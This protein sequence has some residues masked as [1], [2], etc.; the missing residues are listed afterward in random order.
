MIKEDSYFIIEWFYQMDLST[1]HIPGNSSET[2]N[3]FALASNL[4]FAAK[5]LLRNETSVTCISET[6]CFP[7][8]K[9]G[10]Y[11]TLSIMFHAKKN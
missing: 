8:V 6:R 2:A 1:R 11:A 3:T 4:Y 9:F 5:S 10:K 7:V